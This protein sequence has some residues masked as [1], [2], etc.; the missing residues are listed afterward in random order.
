VL[1]R[2]H[3]QGPEKGCQLDKTKSYIDKTIE[4]SL[5]AMIILVPALFYTRTNDVFE[6]NKMFVFRLFTIMGVFLWIISAVRD[7]KITLMRTDLDFPVIGLLVTSILSTVISKNQNTSFYGVYED[8]EGIFT[9]LNYFFFYYLA[10]N[11]L[12][13][14]NFV[15][16]TIVMILLTTALISGYGIAQ[17]FGWDFVRWNPETYSPERFFSTLGNPNFL[18][19]YLVETIP[20]IFIVFFMTRGKKKK[21]CVLGVLLMA[22]VV[23]FLTKSRAGFFSLIITI[24]LTGIYS[25]IDS[26][27][28]ENELFSKNKIWFICFGALVI[29]TLFVPMVRNA[30]AMVWERS[31]GLFTLKGIVL[32][33]RVY[34][35]KSAL[36]MFR[37]FP[38]LGTGI[39]TFQ[40]MFPYYRF[41]IYWQLEWN[42]TPE[43]THNVFLQVLATQGIAGFGFYALLFVTFLKKSFN[44]MFGEKEINK[45]YLIFGFFM[46]AVAFYAQGLFNYT[47]VAYGLVF[48]L[49]LAMIMMLGSTGKRAYVYEFSDAYSGMLNRNKI[50]IYCLLAAAFIAMQ[51]QVVKYWASDMYFKVGN[52]ATSSDKDEYSI[53]Y[54]QRAV[55]FSPEREIYWVKY[56]IAFEKVLRKESNPQKRLEYLNEAIKIHMHTIEMNRMNGYNYNNVARVYKTYGEL[57]DRSKYQDAVYNYL[58]AIKRDPNNAYFGLDLASVYISTQ[59]WDKALE[60]SKRYSELYPDFA[61]PLSY[62]GYI[63]ML[64]AQYNPG[65]VRQLM[66]LAKTYYEQAV[67][68]P[69]WHKDMVTQASTYSNLGIIYFNLKM[70]KEAADVFTKVIQIRPDYVEGYLNLGKLYTLMKNRDMAVQMYETALKVNPNDD[71]VITELKRMGVRTG[72]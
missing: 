62:M 9:V 63:Y 24:L 5:L 21:M 67:A 34:I 4:L 61:V 7:K 43:K 68:K 56:G 69:E 47:V 20:L 40:V 44:L 36:M 15:P 19:A 49:A 29:L 55:D 46:C 1:K 8:Y 54:Y 23:V 3:V 64:E 14:K 30:F 45:R 38:V 26:R 31:K 27:K 22:V 17:N 71:R 10:V 2:A 6:I 65:M 72:Q 25:F 57:L 35:W 52:I 42:G 59:E 39:D 16:K 70:L 41:P 33:P 13:L 66:P 12:G 18:A 50:L 60:L 28:A 58:E 53:Y 32:T 37:D 51:V 48:W 11:Y